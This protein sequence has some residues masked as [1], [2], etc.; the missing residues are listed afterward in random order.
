MEV[1][2]EYL[3]KVWG[4][5]AQYIPSYTLEL[6]AESLQSK[7]GEVFPI[8]VKKFI[9]VFKITDPVVV[10]PPDLI[11]RIG[12]E[13]SIRVSIPGLLKAEGRGLVHGEIDYFAESGEFFFF[14]PTL[15][16]FDIRGL[17]SRYQEEVRGLFESIMRS[18][19]SDMSVFKF[20]EEDKKQRIAKRMLKSVRVE[21]ERLKIQVG[22]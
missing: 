17:P 2:K 8:K 1:I 22:F 9:F 5:I 10:I 16:K 14:E 7:I 6:K 19:L 12:I 20:N 15:Q 11:D 18:A 4:F 3:L 21:D 13:V